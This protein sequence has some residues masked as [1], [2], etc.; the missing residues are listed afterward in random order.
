MAERL[1]NTI[2]SP[3]DHFKVCLLIA[4]CQFAVLA[5]RHFVTFCGLQTE[6][7][8]SANCR[9]MAVHAVGPES[10]VQV[11]LCNMLVKMLKMVENVK[12]A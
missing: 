7:E 10:S 1:A 8:S 6:S 3:T 2:F 11:S 12:D 4:E 9:F 5:K